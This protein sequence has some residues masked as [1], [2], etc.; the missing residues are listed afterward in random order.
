M[1]VWG[2]EGGAFR[3]QRDSEVIVIEVDGVSVSVGR[4]AD[5]YILVHTVELIYLSRRDDE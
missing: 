4:I 5:L 2:V 1:A 3:C